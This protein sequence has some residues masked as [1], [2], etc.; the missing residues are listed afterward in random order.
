MGRTWVFNDGQKNPA[1]LF[2][3]F[4]FF[5][6]CWCCRTHQENGW[7][8]YNPPIPYTGFASCVLLSI[9]LRMALPS[10]FL[11]MIHVHGQ[12]MPMPLN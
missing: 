11:Q 9:L 7:A 10:G 2:E 5:L 8:R 6:E 12:G 3:L 4:A 1:W